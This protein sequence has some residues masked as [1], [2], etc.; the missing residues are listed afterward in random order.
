MKDDAITQLLD[1]VMVLTAR[2]QEFE[3]KQQPYVSYSPLM[4][5]QE[6]F[7]LILT[8]NSPYRKKFLK[9]LLR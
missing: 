1:Q 4:T 7:L 8:H 9:K 6:T 3:R 5:T 2:M